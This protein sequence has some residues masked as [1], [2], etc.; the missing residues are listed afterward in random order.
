MQKLMNKFLL[1]NLVLLEPFKATVVMSNGADTGTS[2]TSEKIY[3]SFSFI[4]NCLKEKCIYS[5]SHELQNGESIRIIAD[6]GDLP[7]NID[8]HTVYFAITGVAAGGN[9][10]DLSATEI[11]I[12]SSKTNADLSDPIFIKTVASTTDK[13]SIISRVSD[14]KPGDAGHPIQYDTTKNR[15]FIH[16]LAS[17]NT[18]HPQIIDTQNP[19]LSTDISYIIRKDDDRSLD[20]KIYKL[21]YV[22]PK[23]LTNGRDPVDGFVLQDSN[24]T[25]VLANTDFNKLT[26]TSSDYAFDRNTRFISQASFDS[27]LNLVSIRSDKPHN[28]KVGDQ[29]IVKNIQSSTNSTGLDDKGYNG[30]FIVDSIINDKE[31]KYSNTDVEN[32]THTVGTFTNNTHT[33]NTLLPRFSRND[34]KD[35]FFVYRTEIVSPYI[36]GVQDGIYHLFVLNAD[37]AMTESS[38]Q[39]TENKYNQNIVNLYPEYDRDN[40]DANPPSPHICKKISTW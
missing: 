31:F 4:C 20:E 2:I 11:R 40:V 29:I 21:R 23:E 33:R 1:I 16:T 18:L 8:P 9:D 6:N 17:G 25:T 10:A 35:N 22:V 19:I 3:E 24:F 27:T 26:I 36:E 5:R 39:F 14:K 13:F 37:N 30:T 12:A 38:G 32:I 28:V 34:N 15:W 7:E